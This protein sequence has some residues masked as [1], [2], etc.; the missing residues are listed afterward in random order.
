MQC[1]SI[2]SILPI[3]E[4]GPQGLEGRVVLHDG[5]EG[6]VARA[7]ELD[8]AIQRNLRERAREV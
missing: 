8:G 6:R 2:Q 4:L 5:L 1:N 3:R 7:T